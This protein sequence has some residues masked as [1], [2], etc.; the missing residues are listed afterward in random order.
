MGRNTPTT[1]IKAAI[2][3][4]RKE[5]RA[6]KYASLTSELKQRNRLRAELDR[7]VRQVVR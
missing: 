4:K 7:L 6:L 1:D 3:A 5:I 2:V